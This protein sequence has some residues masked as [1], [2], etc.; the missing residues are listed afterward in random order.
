M[1]NGRKMKGY[2]SRIWLFLFAGCFLFS[3]FTVSWAG[4]KAMVEQ[5]TKE[6]DELNKEAVQQ[7]PDLP[8]D[9]TVELK[10][11]V[12]LRK[13]K[14]QFDIYHQKVYDAE[15]KIVEPD[16]GN[17]P[18]NG[19]AKEGIVDINNKKDTSKNKKD[20]SKEGEKTENDPEDN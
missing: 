20:T 6:L 12:K 15:G 8:K 13:G 10:A 11:K 16:N 18:D 7:I 14:T 17:S 4:N 5:R 1:M 2:T 9:G 19:T 3:L